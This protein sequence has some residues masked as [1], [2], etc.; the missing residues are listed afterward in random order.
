[1]SLANEHGYKTV[2]LIQ[3]KDKGHEQLAEEVLA[4]FSSLMQQ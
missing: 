2:S 4:Y 3:V 1:V